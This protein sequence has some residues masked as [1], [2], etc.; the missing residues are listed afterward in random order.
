MRGRLRQTDLPWQGSTPAAAQSSYEAAVLAERTAETD[1]ATVLRFIRS[2][3]TF[4]ATDAEIERALGSKDWP[5]NIVTA[6]R[7]DLVLAGKV[8]NPVP[9][10]RA[11]R[12]SVKTPKLKV[13]VWIASEFAR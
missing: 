8:V 10:A 13:T 1:C 5:A 4:G 7:N 9:F 2:R 11:R 12:K 6:R 3:G